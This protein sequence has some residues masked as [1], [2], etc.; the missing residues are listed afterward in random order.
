M[1]SGTDKNR[2][3][4]I[5]YIP[6]GA[7]LGIIPAMV[8]ARLEELTETPAIELFQV[9]DG[10][11]TGSILAAGMNVRDP[12]DPTKPKYTAQE[13]V[14][15]FCSYGPQFF[16]FIYN[17]YYKL[18]TSALLSNLED[19]TDPLKAEAWII[20]E[21][22]TKQRE[23]AAKAPPHLQPL[24]EEFG[25]LAT[26]QWLTKKG[27]QRALEICT[28]IDDKAVAELADALGG[29][30]FLRETNGWAAQIFRRSALYGMDLVKKTWARDFLYDASIPAAAY[31]ET[32]GQ[33]TMKNCL[34][35]TYISTYDMNHDCMKI[36]SCRKE[37]FFSTDP[38]TPSVVSGDSHKL[39]DAVM[40]S[41]ANPFAFPSHITEEGIACTDKAPFHTPLPCLFDVFANKPKDAN[42]K[43]VILGTGKFTALQRG[44]KASNDLRDEYARYS[45]AGNILRGREVAQIEAGI[46]SEMREVIHRTLGEGNIIEFSPFLGPRTRE[47]LDE[48]PSKDVLD[49]TEENVRK[50]VNRAY[51][52]V[53]E[54]DEN[55]RTLA[56]QLLE[57]VH[58]LG[59]MDDAKYRRVMR[60]I[61]LCD[62]PGSPACQEQKRGILHRMFPNGP[63]TISSAFTT[64]AS[65]ITREPTPEQD[66]LPGNTPTRRSG[67]DAPHKFNH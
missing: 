50:I 9:V 23:L 64:L 2:T 43:L 47:E 62:E 5:L 53:Q 63:L 25:A 65:W 44:N 19:Q 21:I 58:N 56:R 3:I 66:N 12:L 18:M 48:T 16:P 14:E 37:D 40:A 29:L 1:A 26:T 17:R 13:M 51:Q 52:Y 49:G 45:V 54:E 22:K 38:K 46:M 32:F 4:F 15:R 55:I 57:N 42:I 33:E 7:M 35:S 10:A 27:K 20:E 41:T 39:W 28:Q 60:N 8:L 30:V 31:Q 36:F 34:R 59:Q 61:G 67:T 11:S 24:V 6:G